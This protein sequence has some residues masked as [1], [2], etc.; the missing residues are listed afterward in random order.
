QLLRAACTLG[1]G[2]EAFRIAH[3]IGISEIARDQ[4]VAVLLLLSAPHITEGTIV[5]HDDGQRNAMMY[6]GRNFIG[7]EEK[8][9]VAR[10]RQYRHIGARV[11]RAERGGVAPAEIVLVAR[12]KERPR[13]V[14]R[15]QEPGGK[16]DLGD[17]VDEDAVFGQL[18]PDRVE[19]ADLRGE[20]V[21]AS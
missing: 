1:L 6:G 16:T 10:D 7:G 14:D 8:A 9:A 18:R 5:E 2:S 15:K 13:L 12:R 21:Q 19:K 4:P 11:L 3:E 17:L 20:L